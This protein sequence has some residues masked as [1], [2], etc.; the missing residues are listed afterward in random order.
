MTR[1]AHQPITALRYGKPEH[2]PKP[3]GPPAAEEHHQQVVLY[4]MEAAG[5]KLAWR[6]VSGHC[7]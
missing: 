6:V 1:A 7:Q 3:A 5:E 2:S 4:C